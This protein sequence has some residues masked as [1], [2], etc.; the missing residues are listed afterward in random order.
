MEKAAADGGGGGTAAGASKLKDIDTP[1]PAGSYVASGA[2]HHQFTH[3]STF[4]LVVIRPWTIIVD[5]AAHT[6]HS[7][8]FLA[9]AT[10]THACGPCTPTLLAPVDPIVCFIML[11]VL[12][13]SWMYF[14]ALEEGLTCAQ[15]CDK[16]HAVH[17]A[18]YEWF[19]CSFDKFGR[20]PTRYVP[21]CRKLIAPVGVLT[22]VSPAL[23]FMPAPILD[24]V[25]RFLAL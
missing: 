19:G 9:A 12:P 16:Y 6:T 10:P 2:A 13:G 21:H 20:T 17:K 8:A 23:S 18:V 25:V 7:K 11:L 15:I 5:G 24:P 14:Q 3:S 4:A 1:M 22:P